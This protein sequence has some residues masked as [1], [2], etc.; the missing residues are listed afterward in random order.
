MASYQNFQ[1]DS[2]KNSKGTNQLAKVKKVDKTA[3]NSA[4]SNRMRNQMKRWTSFYRAN[5]HRFVESYLGIELHLFQK[6]MMYFMNINLVFVLVASRGISKSFT[7]G[8]FACAK[9]ILYP[10]TKVVIA[11]GVKKQASL[12]ITEKIEKELMNMSPNLAR[13]IKKI[14]QSNG[15]VSVLFHNGSSI[16]STVS[17]ENAR[18]LRANMLILEEFRLIKEDVLNDTLLPFLNVYRQ[19]PFLK[20]KEYKH[21]TEE[22]VEIYISSA[23]YTSHWMWKKMKS[24][25]DA[26]FKNEDSM[27]F[28]LDYLTAIYHGLL[29]PKRI[30][31]TKRKS[32]F[33][34]TSFMIEYENIMFFQNNDAYFKLDD[35]IKNRN[36]KK[37]VYPIKNEDYQNQ[38]NK[39]KEKLKDGEIRIMAVDVALMG[40]NTNDST[41][42][43]CMRLIP[44][45]DHYLKKV[46]YIEQ[47]PEGG[48]TDEQAIR[49]KQLFEDFQMSKVALDTMGNGIE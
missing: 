7:L 18:G 31:S 43:T 38:K 12:I 26:M 35:I 46:I 17:N 40:G 23:W 20:K 21:L 19:P 22:N 4:K 29:S 36:I 45:G 44:N 41:I 25:R 13:E 3:E 32:D 33:D 37:A 39:K 8:L 5:I 48:H 10:G 47:L 6:I 27:I 1:T 2:R 49:I 24:T 30:E 42:V 9:C 14:N 16:V 28:S 11:S 15:E 34:E